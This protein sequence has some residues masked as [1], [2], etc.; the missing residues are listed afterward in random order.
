MSFLFICFER[1]PLQ[2][3][4]VYLS[5]KHAELICTRLGG[6][7]GYKPGEKPLGLGVDL[8]KGAD[9]GFLI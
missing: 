8:V 6:G 7:A 2:P 5:A 4:S 1:Q 9:P 3:V